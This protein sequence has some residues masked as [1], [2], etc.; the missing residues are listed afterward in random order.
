MK[1][2]KAYAI[3]LGINSDKFTDE[4]K[5]AAISHIADMATHNSV[6]KSA[7]IDVIRWLLAHGEVFT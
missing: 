7:M 4:E 5:K 3:F 6:P 2:G 1:P